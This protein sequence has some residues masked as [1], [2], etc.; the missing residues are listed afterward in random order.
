MRKALVVAICLSLSACSTYSLV[1]QNTKSKLPS[2]VLKHSEGIIEHPTKQDV[3]N[4]I[5]LGESSKDDNRLEYAYIHKETLS[6]FEHSSIFA[7]I[8]TP[9][10]LIAEHSKKQ[11]RNYEILDREYIN[12]CKKLNVVAITVNR[13]YFAKSLNR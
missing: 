4:A 1:E 5:K 10:Y 11:S 7:Y 3:D 9:L 2:Y 8:S 6:S 12:Y 13:Q